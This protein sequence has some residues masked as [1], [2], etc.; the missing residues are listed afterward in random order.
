MS[1]VS[2]AVPKGEPWLESELKLIECARTGRDWRPSASSDNRLRAQVIVDLISDI[3]DELK[4]T[5][6]VIHPNG[7]NIYG[8][9]IITDSTGF[10]LDGRKLRAKLWFEDCEFAESDADADNA[11][12]AKVVL[13]DVVGKTIAIKSSKTGEVDARRMS[14]EG[15]FYFDGSIA[16]Q[17]VD[18]HNARIEGYFSARGTTLGC[19]HPNTGRPETGY[20]LRGIAIYVG[21]SVDL[22]SLDGQASTASGKVSFARGQINGRLDC[23]Q[24]KI[25][26]T[27]FLEED[28]G[29]RVALHLDGCSIG[30]SLLIGE[31]FEAEGA[32]KILRAF[33]GAD[34]RCGGGIFRTIDPQN[35]GAKRL[36]GTFQRRFA[37]A[38]ASQFE[39]ALDLRSTDVGEGLYLD[40]RFSKQ[41]TRIE[42]GLVLANASCE[43]FCDGK[44]NSKSKAIAQPPPGMLELDGFIYERLGDCPTSWKTRERWLMG[45]IKEHVEENFRPQPWMHL[46]HVLDQ[47]GYKEASRFIAIKRHKA[48]RKSNSLNHAQRILN[49]LLGLFVGHG[50]KPHYAIFCSL[51][52]IVPSYFIFSVAAQEGWMA[53]QSDTV[54]TSELYWQNPNCRT[55]D[56][57]RKLDAGYYVLDLF[58]PILDQQHEK[59]WGPA[60]V[61]RDCAKQKADEA[62]SLSLQR[63]WNA[64]LKNVYDRWLK[65]LFEARLLEHVR[66]ILIVAGWVLVPLFLA[67]ATGLMKRFEY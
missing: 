1:V 3:D 15:N 38:T 60:A 48:L 11:R 47:M 35:N 53:P 41:R 63:I 29:A 33:I 25:T 9:R 44:A 14:L 43:V 2:F 40:D 17:G 32:V 16:Q 20:S 58:M 52:F 13:R 23:R 8:A 7:L 24:M 30:E 26:A 65:G 27:H 64:E 50:Y 5:T 66:W 12:Y 57:Y 62:P 34:L 51:I 67:G 42:G 54:M 28:K 39:V 10:S 19:R 56:V 59:D 21:D 22:R 55:P 36:F 4:Y 31:G 6:D 18:L 46:I 49:W 45:Q 61:Q 37:G